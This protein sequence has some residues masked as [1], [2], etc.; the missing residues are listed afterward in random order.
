[1]QAQVV[2]K[3][4]EGLQE[5]EAQKTLGSVLRFWIPAAKLPL[6]CTVVPASYRQQILSGKPRIVFRSLSK[7]M[8]PAKD[9]VLLARR[10]QDKDACKCHVDL[11]SCSS[12]CQKGIISGI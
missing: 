3:L 12:L 1:M 5:K 9:G 11:H 10:L 2:G 6:L 8:T 7:V 4:V